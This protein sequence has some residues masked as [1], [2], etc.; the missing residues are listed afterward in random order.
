MSDDSIKKQ[1]IEQ[2]SGNAEKY[3]TSV[4]HATG[5]DLTELVEW[6]QPDPAWSLLDIATGGGHVA[7]TLAPHVDR[8]YATDLTRTMLESARRHLAP[9]RG[10]VT[11]VVADAEAL[12][13]L[14]AT[15]DAAVCRIAAHHFPNPASFVAEA[16]RV[17]KLGGAFVLIDNISPPDPK[18]DQFMNTTEKT[19]DES[20]VRCYSEAEWRA[21]FQANGLEVKASKIRKKTFDFPV[22]VKVTTRSDE[23][24]E[25]VANHLLGADA[26]TAEYFGIQRDGDTIRS[27]HID[28][29]MVMLQKA[30]S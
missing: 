11:Y 13:F 24:V 22:W 12:P 29:W 3:V 30:N 14:D 10:N 18:L 16:S 5:P 26:V 20:H 7:K 4:S 15:F 17:L 27:F 21:W 25:Q 1:V 9:L 19:R 2:F 6:L 28:E 8:V 23:Q